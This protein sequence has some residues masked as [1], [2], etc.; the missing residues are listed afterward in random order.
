M[1]IEQLLQGML[2]RS[3]S[4]LHLKVG[5]P[6][7]LRIHG[8]LVPQ[9]D[10]P[11]PDERDM[12]D[13]LD[14]L[15][16]PH[17]REAFDRERELDFAYE[18]G[19]MARFRVNAARQRGSIYLTLRAIPRTVPTLAELGLPQVCARL[20]LLP[21]GLVL[22]TGPT[23]CG[24]STTLAAMIEHVNRTVARRI[25]TLE[26]PIEYVF[27]DRLS[28]ITQREV[29]S[30]T[31]SF[32]TG[33]KYALRQ[34]PDV[35]M[36]GEMRDL[37]TIA[38]TLT[39]AETGHLVLAT[40]HTPS[41]PEAVDRIVDVFPAHQQAQVRT[42]VAMTLAGVI[43]QRLIPRADG[44]GRVAAC[45]VLIGTPAV[46]NLIRERKTPQMVSVMQTG[47][48]HGMQTMNQAL[49]DLYRRGLITLEEAQA[50]AT[51]M[52]DFKRLL[53]GSQPPVT[54]A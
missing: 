32:A 45:E 22:V 27:E 53:R 1:R 26:D 47:R 15:V 46:R 51:D 2:E 30:D 31:R 36:V 39:A 5:H 37:E 54:Q 52:D 25:V 17:E 11:V 49:Y 4:D 12:E 35:I 23:G 34:D 10:W 21:Q 42:Q 3:A 6:P 20:A 19:E 16:G 48:E 50:H 14:Q 43:A 18:M 24:K 33:L 7:V 8:Q 28:V 13:L 9:P 40:L 38:A 44:T 29:G 41:A